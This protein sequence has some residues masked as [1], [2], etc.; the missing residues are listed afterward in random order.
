M[1]NRYILKLI[2]YKILL[3]NYN[4]LNQQQ[5]V[6]VTIR[7]RRNS[8]LQLLLVSHYSWSDWQLHYRIYHSFSSSGR[9]RYFYRPHWQLVVSHRLSH[10][11]QNCYHSKLQLCWFSTTHYV[12]R[13]PVTRWQFGL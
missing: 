10:S 6:T 3:I 12:Y 5:A 1:Q 13:C 8:S 9:I 2:N 7:A 4:F 11:R